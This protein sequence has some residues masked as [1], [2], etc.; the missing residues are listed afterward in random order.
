MHV[1]RIFC[2]TPHFVST[3]I[4]FHLNTDFSYHFCVFYRINRLALL[5]DRFLKKMLLRRA[6]TSRFPPPPAKLLAQ[7][8]RLLYSG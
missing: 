6:N 5:K 7:M 2:R 3:L 1:I 8:I 4:D